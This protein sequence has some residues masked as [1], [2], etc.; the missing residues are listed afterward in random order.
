MKY[1]TMAYLNIN[2][3]VLM[4]EKIKRNDDPNSGF[5]TL[6][7]GK[8]KES[9]KGSSPYGRLYSCLRETEEETG[10][11]LIRPILKGVVLFDN[12]E[13]IFDNWKNPQDFLVH[14][15]SADEYGGELKEKTKEGTPHFLDEKL[16]SSVPQNSGDK[17]LY[18]WLRDGRNFSGVIRHKGK[19][20]DESGT[21]VDY[22]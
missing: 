6:P 1:G 21:F 14:I 19:D 5:W 13:K 18:E 11:I 15:Y 10:I 17:K 12:S 2:G 3:K 8:L 7:G 16:L 9:E 20:L 22:Y 4:L